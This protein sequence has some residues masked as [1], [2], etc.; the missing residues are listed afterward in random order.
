[1]EEN[2]AFELE[3]KLE[4]E[5]YRSEEFEALEKQPEDPN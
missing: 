2:Q 5:D 1:M 4:D 3:P